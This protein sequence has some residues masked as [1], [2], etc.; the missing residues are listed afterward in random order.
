MAQQV[1]EQASEQPEKMDTT[2]ATVYDEW[3]AADGLFAPEAS[4]KTIS[5]RDGFV[6]VRKQDWVSISEE[7]WAGHTEKSFQ[8]PPW[9]YCEVLGSAQIKFTRA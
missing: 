5:F 4:A 1:E 6:R 8:V 7:G 2:A 9:H 3:K